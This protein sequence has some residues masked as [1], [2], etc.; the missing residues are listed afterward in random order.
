MKN[1]HITD[2]IAFW[3]VTSA[4]L[5]AALIFTIHLGTKNNALIQPAVSQDASTIDDSKN[6]AASSNPDYQKYVI[7][8]EGMELGVS[9]GDLGSLLIKNG[10]IDQDKFLSLYESRGGL[11][12]DLKALLEPNYNQPLKISP[13]N[14][15]FLLNL[16][17]AL[18]LGNKNSILEE[19]PM[20]DPRFGG[21]DRFASTG[22]WT[23]AKGDAMDHYSKYTF[24]KL[25]AK[26]QEL[27]ER[28][29]KNIYRPC[30]GNSTYFPDCNHGMAMLGLL[31][32]MA[33]QGADE[34]RMYQTALAVNSYWFP[35]TYLTLAKYYDTKGISWQN[36][37]PKELLD[38][39][40]SSASG[41]SQIQTQVDPVQFNGGGGCG[42]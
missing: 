24:I 11:E 7:P 19:G 9:W 27:V 20:Q 12:P 29:S 18:G 3:R 36:I 14:S 17:W 40:H 34:N 1:N 15:Q 13:E 41:F 23:L 32:L 35:Q 22:G 16:F 38:V 39:Q 8:E 10:V 42:V 33:S 4:I 6:I 5:L 28:V 21:A 25:T 30:C 26:Q 2:S 37:D 31:E